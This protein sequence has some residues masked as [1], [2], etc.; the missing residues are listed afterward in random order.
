MPNLEDA[1]CQRNFVIH[2]AFE[3]PNLFATLNDI[4]HM[5]QPEIYH[6]V[7]IL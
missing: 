5:K 7:S 6:A 4:G 3:R 1:V 2:L